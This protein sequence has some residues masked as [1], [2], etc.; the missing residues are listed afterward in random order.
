MIKKESVSNVNDTRRCIL[1][2][3]FI[4]NLKWRRM[5][6]QYLTWWVFSFMSCQTCLCSNYK[7]TL[8]TPPPPHPTPMQA[9]LHVQFTHVFSQRANLGGLLALHAG[10]LGVATSEIEASGGDN[11]C[12]AAC[13]TSAPRARLQEAM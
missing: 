5:K 2:H 4:P 13:V 7:S 3:F 12:C 1:K 11:F 9:I 10:V 6:G 8:R